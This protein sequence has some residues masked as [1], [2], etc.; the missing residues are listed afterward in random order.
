MP[1]SGTLTAVSSG[2]GTPRQP[3]DGSMVD[4]ENFSLN[5]GVSLSTAFA[6]TSLSTS[7]ETGAGRGAEAWA[8]LPPSRYQQD[9]E[10][11]GLIGQG[12]QGKVFR[13]RNRTDGVEYAVKRIRIGGADNKMKREM[14]M[15][16]TLHHPHIVR[17]Y[18]AW[19]EQSAGPQIIAGE[20]LCDDDDPDATYYSTSNV[21]VESCASSRVHQYLY[22][23]MEL[24]ENRTLETLLD[25]GKLRE[26]HVFLWQVLRQILEALEYLHSMGVVHR[27][28]KPANVFIDRDNNVKIGD[29][30]LAVRTPAAQALHAVASDG[31]P[32]ALATGDESRE[33]TLDRAQG[34]RSSPALP[35]H[36]RT[37]DGLPPDAA[38]PR[39]T[40]PRGGTLS[41]G[42]GTPMYMAPEQKTKSRYD[43]QADMF[44]VGMMLFE[45][46]MG[47]TKAERSDRFREM[48]ALRGQI[49]DMLKG[50]AS[51]GRVELPMSFEQRAFAGKYRCSIPNCPENALTTALSSPAA[52]EH[53][54]STASAAAQ[55][56]AF[57]SA[58][59]PAS[60]A[61]V[62]DKDKERE[63]K[64]QQRRARRAG[65]PSLATITESG[66][67]ADIP[68]TPSDAS[69]ALPPSPP[70]A[71]ASSDEAAHHQLHVR[72]LQDLK[73]DMATL[74][75]L[76]R[77]L[78]HPEPSR[79]FTAKQVLASGLIPLTIDQT[80]VQPLLAE[81]L[82]DHTNV[83][84]VVDSLF[85]RDRCP[86]QDDALI[87]DADDVASLPDLRGP[88]QALQQVFHRYAA[89]ETSLP[90]LYA[91]TTGPSEAELPGTLTLLDRVGSQLQAAENLLLPWAR[92]LAHMADEVARFTQ[93]LDATAKTVHTLPL[94]R[95]EVGKTWH[96]AHKAAVAEETHA[97]YDIAWFGPPRT[98]ETEKSREDIDASRKGLM[99]TLEAATFLRDALKAA[100]IAPGA[101]T[102]QVGHS[103]LVEV[104]VAAATVPALRL[105]E[106][107]RIEWEAGKRQE[108][109]RLE[110]RVRGRKHGNKDGKAKKDLPTVSPPRAPAPPP[111]PPPP[112][113]FLTQV[114]L[115]HTRRPASA[116]TAFPPARGGAPLPDDDDP[117][118]WPGAASI[119]PADAT[120]ADSEGPV[121]LHELPVAAAEALLEAHV[122]ALV[123]RMMLRVSLVHA[124]IDTNLR[125]LAHQR[126][127]H[128]WV[129]E[130]SIR[131]QVILEHAQF[132]LMDLAPAF[133]AVP[134]DLFTP[135]LLVDLWSALAGQAPAQLHGD[136]Q[137][138]Q[139]AVHRVAYDP[140]SQFV[141]KHVPATSRHAE[142]ML[143]QC[144]RARD[145]LSLLAHLLTGAGLAYTLCMATAVPRPSLYSGVV[146]QAVLP[147]LL[148]TDPVTVLGY[149]GWTD[150]LIQRLTAAANAAKHGPAALTAGPGAA[151][152]AHSAWRDRKYMCYAI[153][154]TVVL[155]AVHAHNRSAS[156]AAHPYAH[157]HALT[158]AAAPAAGRHGV[159]VYSAANSMVSRLPLS[160]KLRAA[161]VRVEDLFEC[162]RAFADK[163]AL[164][165]SF[166]WLVS[167][168]LE[169]TG[170]GQLFRVGGGR[171]GEPE[172]VE[173]PALVSLLADAPTTATQDTRRGAGAAEGKAAT[174][175]VSW[176]TI[177]AGVRRQYQAASVSTACS[178]LPAAHPKYSMVSDLVTMPASRVYAVAL[179]TS[180]LRQ[181]LDAAGKNECGVDTR[182][183][184]ALIDD[185]REQARAAAYAAEL[186]DQVRL[187]RQS[188]LKYVFVYSTTDDQTEMVVI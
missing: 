178:T 170:Q 183:W 172:A 145:E 169:P 77:S 51:V 180:A 59:A 103:D 162:S 1:G 176:Y 171:V 104:L 139:A 18:Q 19:E 54:A 136:P 166:R 74:P 168:P 4:L 73:R 75:R 147:T 185:R 23:A 131:R 117:A 50:K 63:K 188:S 3:A 151:L 42:I 47:W 164:A 11:L 167:L 159:L 94:R 79:R 144:R 158:P 69:T 38:S 15:F 179:P 182:D 107:R 99:Y 76:L 184:T 148:V 20:D 137:P 83:R 39:H 72:Y 142:R 58:T 70:S 8:A 31:D 186:I 28:L 90:S 108:Q 57:T 68:G 154:A 30:G 34:A 85:T 156:A 14:R 2:I 125:D 40:D 13:A 33:H 49:T 96:G 141:R 55:A 126:R 22:I 21:T 157:A 124:D 163:H 102:L 78:L 138:N 17:Y 155:D 130:A 122:R 101:Y 67:D 45:T 44:S 146:F 153:N 177:S 121:Q 105:L 16:S 111:P 129:S 60:S 143:Y 114:T 9:Y 48:A 27:D 25:E 62:T 149:G 140:V 71:D 26:D 118:G 115:T 150:Q 92:L 41:H 53:A 152:T 127:Q 64:K 128:A 116:S 5:A 132:T 43:T 187:C 65:D 46:W 56:S 6:P 181:V 89:R 120:L 160:A 175:N 37:L 91:R 10:H 135:D 66:T 12:G 82:K 88:K 112:A 161:G 173:L 81:A 106:P 133:P 52:S 24:C 123:R 7:P 80:A 36:A 174:K 95:G 86:A 134:T 87:F 110:A 32:A 100:G 165:H 93:L 29:F 98:R 119:G 97:S 109:E 113:D 35:G 61:S 84:F